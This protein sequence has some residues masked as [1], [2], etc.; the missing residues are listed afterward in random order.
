MKRTSVRRAAIANVLALGALSA[1][2][3]AVAATGWTARATER[4]LTSSRTTIYTTNGGPDRLT[5]ARC[6]GL[7]QTAHGTYPGFSCAV[8][9]T[10]PN[11]P[12]I[13][14][15]A[16][17]FTRPWSAR[18][19]CISEVSLGACPPPAPA[20]GAPNDPRLCGLPNQA[21]CVAKAVSAAMTEAV[22]AAAVGN[23]SLK[24]VVA[25]HAGAAWTRYSCNW[26]RG[27]PAGTGTVSISRASAGWTVTANVT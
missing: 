26:H 27:I 6:S 24:V 3:P 25:C 1:L 21:Q 15:H 10:S 5:G 14:G 4:L 13:T 12:T 11:D 22:T 8:T 9:W 17:M 16:T 7:G 18:S 23:Q 20:Q 19:A 2:A